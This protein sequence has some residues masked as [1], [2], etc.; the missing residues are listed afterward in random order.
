MEAGE[1]AVAATAAAMAAEDELPDW[2]RDV[3]VIV[4]DEPALS[5]EAEEAILA[6]VEPEEVVPADVPDWLQ[7]AVAEEEISPVGETGEVTPTEEPETEAAEAEPVIGPA[8]VE[9]AEPEAEETG[10]LVEAG[11]LEEEEEGAIPAGAPE[12]DIP[13]WLRELIGGEAPSAAEVPEEPAVELGS[14]AAVAAVAGI[15]SHEEVSEEGGE[16][17]APEEEEVVTEIIEAEKAPEVEM[18]AS[19]SALVDA[20]LLDEA[21]LET[22][23]AEMSAEDLA[24]QQAEDIPI[25]LQELIGEAAEPA[26]EE[27]ALKEAVP[28][29]EEPSFRE[30]DLL[31]AEETPAWLR[32]LTEP[33]DKVEVPSVA[34]LPEE[35]EAAEEE[36]LAPE[37]TEVPVSGEPEEEAPVIEEVAIPV[38]GEPEEEAP[39][40]EEVAIPVIGEPEEEALVVEEVAI[41]VVG[42]PEE[43][44]PVVEEVAIPVI[45]EPEEEVP[46]VEE[47]A[48]PVVGEPE[49]ERLVVKGVTAPA[50]EE[51]E[52]PPSRV[53]ELV[54]Q[55]KTRP[56][57]TN[58]R[59]ELARLYVAEQDWDAALA[60]Y[61]KL[62]SARK[63]LPD[64]IQDLEPL[65]QTGVD[66]A[67]LYQLLGDAYMH[68]DQLDRALQMYRQARQSLA[69]R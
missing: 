1:V 47:V 35:A 12:E 54:E 17:E 15:V 33:A 38:I 29:A 23:I 2:L 8:V 20:G 39:V 32:E 10:W 36:A 62:V 27:A 25:W 22:A 3:G 46:V 13:E 68:Q 31:P 28:T 55:L 61:G 7:E 18:P 52:G 9:E 66:R 43:E 60:Q 26:S 6:E 56:R 49:G 58:L 53:D 16:L 64:V 50:T 30:G 4:E 67:Q 37:E 21:D 59:L 69:R 14:A 41:P 5:M 45:G 34:A 63:Q 48:I 11:I 65:E 24:S 44:A 57:D 51:E 19:L 40:V 42:E